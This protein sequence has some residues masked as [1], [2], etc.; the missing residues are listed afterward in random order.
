MRRRRARSG[1]WKSSCSSTRRTRWWS[2][3]LVTS[4]CKARWRARARTGGAG[5]GWAPYSA[6]AFSPGVRRVSEA[7]GKSRRPGS[8]NLLYFH[9]FLSPEW[10]QTL[11][12]AP[13]LLLLAGPMGL[14]ALTDP[15]RK[16]ILWGLPF[17]P[18]FQLRGGNTRISRCLPQFSHPFTLWFSF[19][20]CA[21]EPSDIW[22][23]GRI[24]AG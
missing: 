22:L 1:P 13:H 12:S 14:G 18:P 15:R 17:R 3:A 9:L 16:V 23:R 10:G 7:F 20:V 4:P 19:L 8:E 6:G 11:P 21:F 24:W 2:A 5:L